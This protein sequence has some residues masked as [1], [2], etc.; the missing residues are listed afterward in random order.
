MKKLFVVIVLFSFFIVGCGTS[1]DHTKEEIRIFLKGEGYRVVENFEVLD[2]SSAVSPYL[3]EGETYVF[4]DNII[5]AVSSVDSSRKF[6][7]LLESEGSFPKISK[8]ILIK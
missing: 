5:I 3:K 8:N 6:L 4:F 7:L 1:P 2:R